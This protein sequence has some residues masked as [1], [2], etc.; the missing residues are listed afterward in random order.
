MGET[1]K[2]K[3]EEKEVCQYKFQ[4]ELVSLFPVPQ[5]LSSTSLS[6]LS[7][8]SFRSISV[9]PCLIKK[10]ENNDDLTEMLLIVIMIIWFF[11]QITYET[12][13]EEMEVETDEEVEEVVE[14]EVVK[15]IIKEVKV[16]QVTVLYPYSGQ[17]LAVRKGEVDMDAVTLC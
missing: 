7:E 17:G 4:Y 6:V 15:D 9:Y 2:E 11:V 5:H 14:K 8:A 10:I 12:Y 16:S 3:T 13:S 1:K